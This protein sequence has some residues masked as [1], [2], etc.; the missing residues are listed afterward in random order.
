[1]AESLIERISSSPEE[2]KLLQQERTILELTELVCAVLEEEGISRAELARRLGKTRGWVTQLLDGEAN[3][4]LRTVSD[5][6]TVL[7][8]QLRVQCEEWD[9]GKKRS[10]GDLRV[11]TT[12]CDEENSENT[13]Y[14]P[15]ST[16][17]A[18]GPELRIAG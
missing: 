10:P 5:V 4:T 18:S 17:V 2:F 6:F 8:K 12:W 7:G 1:M 15:C 14:F 9:A 16:R 13:Y 11:R 3:M